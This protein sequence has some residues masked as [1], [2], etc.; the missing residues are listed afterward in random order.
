MALAEYVVRKVANKKR[1][2]A[3]VQAAT[4]SR[5]LA[6]IMF[7]DM[8]GYTAMSQKDEA[9]AVELLEEQ[10]RILRPIFRK[11]NGREIDTI[12]D[13]FLVEF[14]NSLDAVK[15]AIEIQT[16]LKKFDEQRTDDRK[17]LLRIGIHLG[18]VIHKG[19]NVG[20]DAVNVAS[21]I[22][23]LASPGG[24]CLSAQVYYTVYNKVPCKFESLGNPHLKNVS[25]P[26]EVF[27][28]SGLGD[29]VR[30]QTQQL[31]LLPKTRIAVLPFSSMSPDPSDEYFADGIT[32]EL[33][34]TISKISSLQVIARTSVIRYKGG[35]KSI[36]EIGRE[37]KVGTILEGSV[38]K[39]GEK[40]RIT[41]QLIDSQDSR[42]LWSET[43]DREFKD[44]FAIQSDISQTVAESLRVRLLEGEK[45]R[46]LKEPTKSTDAYMLYL[47]GRQALHDRTKEGMEKAI[48]LFEKSIQI[49]PSYALAYSGLSDAF[50]LIQYWGYLDGQAETYPKAE[51]A[52]KQALAIDENL[53]EAHA[54][55]SSVFAWKYYDYVRAEKEVKRAIELDPSYAYA[56]QSYGIDLVWLG[57]FDEALRELRTAFRLDPVSYIPELYIARITFFRGQYESALEQYGELVK[58][59]ESRAHWI[60]PDI[61]GIYFFKGDY[62][63]ATSEM[64]RAVELSPPEERQS[65]E[66]GYLLQL[67]LINAKKGKTDESMKIL[68]EI[69][70]KVA[71]G[72]ISDP[73]ISLDIASVY[74]AL[75]KNDQAFQWLERAYMKHEFIQPLKV[76]PIFND[77][78]SDPKFV[79]F[80]KKIGLM[81]SEEA[82]Q[83]QR[84]IQ[85]MQSE[86]STFDKNRIAILPFTN[87]SPDPNDEYFADGLT[88][89]MINILS[90]IRGLRVIARTSVNHY[91]KT[92]KPISQIAQELGV[93]T[94]LEGSVRKAGNKVRATLQLIDTRTQEHE[95]SQNYDRTLEDIFEIQ[96]D[97]ARQ[98]AE[99]LKVKILVG[100]GKLIERK[101][102]ENTD[103]YL[104]Y[105]RGRTLLH[106]RD[107]KNLREAKKQFELALSLDS[108]F[109]R[110]LSGLADVDS[111]LETYADEQR[112]L[113][114]DRSLVTNALELDPNL[115]EAHASFANLLHEDFKFVQAERE[116]MKAIELNPSYALAHHWHALLLED[117]GMVEEAFSEFRLAEELDPLSGITIYGQAQLYLWLQRLDEAEQKIQRLGEL[118]GADRLY[119]IALQ[120]YWFAKRD[121]EKLLA[122]IERFKESYNAKYLAAIYASYYIMKGEKERAVAEIAR[123]ESA[124]ERLT[125]RSIKLAQLYAAVGN[126]DVAFEW[127]LKAFDER[128][129]E[130]R[131]LVLDSD[132]API[133]SDPRFLELVTKTD[134]KITPA[135]MNRPS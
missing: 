25:M 39:D 50:F 6:A 52:A 28:I 101:V 59:H 24:V 48:D 12:G 63:K 17:I 116:Y 3:H 55:M 104:A 7:T 13:A 58:R 47:K 27:R 54:S 32:E 123:F 122:E 121:H 34:S 19:K 132:F 60:I 15:C 135:V 124:P 70:P 100:E 14:P 120:G 62:E 110:A 128:G 64:R 96:T 91:K 134:L 40:L 126:L 80:L 23:P 83:A 31:T 33:I 109:A 92:D 65:W 53:A 21:R 18:D 30:P 112:N 8:V 114:L 45:E 102:T 29:R 73:G 11:H 26:V 127:L 75:R 131:F 22:E 84:E 77:F 105:L 79:A 42:H 94:I 36:E 49:D 74:L 71:E 119:S 115:A 43:Y 41:A 78:R 118:K 111:L 107:A 37:L 46:I 103:A 133:R 88:E 2:R 35:S 95:W 57:R 20:G 4:S 99:N 56:H 86:Q 98:V 67:A 85:R 51:A 108:N 72:E 93:G 61:A 76:H 117:K 66:R 68:K 130:F 1:N 113:D 38:R 87:I 106:N 10:R 125:Y 9:L 82:L 81:T 97:I 5:K 89:E 44:V 69:E 16:F 129:L 90:Q